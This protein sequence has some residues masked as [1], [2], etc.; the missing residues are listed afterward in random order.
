MRIRFKILSSFLYLG[1][2]NSTRVPFGPFDSLLTS[3]CFCFFFFIFSFLCFFPQNILSLFSFFFLFHFIFYLPFS[4][5]DFNFFLFL[6]SFTPL[7][8]LSLFLDKSNK[9]QLVIFCLKLSGMG[10]S[11]GF[12]NTLCCLVRVK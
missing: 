9:K 7:L 10:D 11:V 12:K 6:F 2:I 5:F 4:C 1:P 3:D 8:S